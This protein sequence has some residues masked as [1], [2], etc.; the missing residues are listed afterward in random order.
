MTQNPYR[1]A[2]IGL[3]PRGS[4]ALECL[5]ST[6][7]ETDSFS[8]IS[9]TLFEESGPIGGGPVYAPEQADTNW[10]N[11]TE[12]ALVLDERPDIVL[13]AIE[14]PKF[15]SYHAWAGLEFDT[16]PT[17]RVDTFPPRS[18]IGDYLHQRCI[19][20]IEPLKKAG[21]VELIQERVDGIKLQDMECQVVT[22]SGDT[23]FADD[24]LITVGH[25]P[26][27]PDAQSAKWEE[28]AP[29]FSHLK[30]H[31]EPYP[32]ENIMPNAGQS[33]QTHVALRGYGL[34]MI[35]VARAFSERFGRFSRREDSGGALVY[36]CHTDDFVMAPFS[37]DGLA[38]GPKPH[39]PLIDAQYVPSDTD[40]KALKAALDN[41]KAQQDATGTEFL[42][43][44]MVPLI[45]K[46]Y[47]N[48]T[49]SYINE[50]PDIQDIEKTVLKWLNDPTTQHNLIMPI[51]GHPS[52]TLQ[53]LIDMAMDEAPIYLDYCAGQVWRHC[54]PTIYDS[55][56]YSALSNEVMAKIIKLD[57]QSKR[58][59]FGPPVESLM[60]LKAL[61]EAGVLNLNVLN[62]PD[63]TLDAEGW[64][65]TTTQGTFTATTMINTVLDGPK[66]NDITS[67]L[68]ESL[69]DRDI[70][71]PA[72]D[73]LGVLTDNSGYVLSGR[74]DSVL[75][76]ALLGRIA[77]GTVIGVDAIL[78]CFGKRPM[79]WA[80]TAVKKMKIRQPNI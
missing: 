78:E 56:S 59:S 24:V 21:L 31:P 46:T 70:F 7:A 57:E 2:I 14:I 52:E 75:P 62:D 19:S 76:I 63:I 10:V 18:Q 37:L 68:L 40:I 28:T 47:Q 12:R 58:Y 8:K 36:T 29:Q 3:G 43:T 30:Y 65:L 77:K 41:R 44:L 13:G 35:D 39:T 60:Q 61:H 33:G 5:I 48:L 9:I 15:A 38:M 11:I 73:E 20:L 72:H 51:T 27:E 49:H 55:L 69:L 23:Y 53:R 79:G 6:L 22:Q 66:I 74:D 71:Q 67:P 50:A 16:W 1:F 25:Q 64:T 80:E 4:Y 17:E 34:A 26:T 42:T 54:Q 45:T 32:V